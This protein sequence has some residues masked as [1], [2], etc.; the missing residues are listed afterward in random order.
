MNNRGVIVVYILC[1][2]F[3]ISFVTNL[4][5]PLMPVI[6]HDFGLSLALALAPYFKP[7][8]SIEVASESV[9]AARTALRL[10]SSLA[11]PHVALG[12][13]YCQ[14]YRWDSASVEFQKALEL[15]SPDDI[16]P[17]IQYGRFLLF[18]G[19]IAAGLRQFLIARSTEPVSAVV[20]SWPAP[21]LTTASK[22]GTSS[23][24]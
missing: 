19:H 1:V 20:R 16:E 22:V 7:I 17:L 24:R 13:V 8:S 5:G 6:I 15:R 2:W 4:I 10:D 23:G 14:A 11:Q 3:V 12:I 21:K 9:S 18:K